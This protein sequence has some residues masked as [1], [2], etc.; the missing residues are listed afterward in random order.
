MCKNSRVIY[1]VLSTVRII[2]CINNAAMA[3][4]PAGYIVQA[5]YSM[6]F[7]FDGAYRG[8]LL[9]AESIILTSE[10]TAKALRCSQASTQIPMLS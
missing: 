9:D 6:V 3:P 5:L 8:K 4:F 10:H 7:G 1:L 2:R